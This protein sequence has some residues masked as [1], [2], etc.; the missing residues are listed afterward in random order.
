MRGETQNAYCE[1]NQYPYIGAEDIEPLLSFLYLIIP[2]FLI[3]PA[4]KPSNL[5]SKLAKLLST[6]QVMAVKC[7]IQSKL[8]SSLYI[9]NLL[10]SPRNR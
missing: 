6:T 2:G 4:K 1:N 10:L 9:I 5:S 7:P 3:S 8:P